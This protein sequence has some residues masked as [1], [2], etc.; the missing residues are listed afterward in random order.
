ML[1]PERIIAFTATS[2]ENTTSALKREVLGENALVVYGG[3]DRP[4][5]IYHRLSPVFPILDIIRILT[6]PERRPALVFCMSRTLTEKLSKRLSGHFKTRYY[7]AGM[8]KEHRLETEKAFLDDDEGVMFCTCA[9]GMG[10]RYSARTPASGRISSG[11]W[12]RQWTQAA[13]AATYATGRTTDLSA[14]NS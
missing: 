2:D 7:H 13:R 3:L 9:Y 8:D 12:D 4:N 1:N 11:P 6:P 10:R 14:S 5:I